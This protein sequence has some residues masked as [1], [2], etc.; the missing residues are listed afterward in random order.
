MKLIKRMQEGNRQVFTPPAVYDGRK[1]MYAANRLPLANG[2]DFQDVR[3]FTSLA[4]DVLD[5]GP[6]SRHS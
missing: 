1:N 6:V 3:T 5:V 4:I 2:A